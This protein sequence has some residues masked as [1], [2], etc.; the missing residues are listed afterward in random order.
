MAIQSQM[1]IVNNYQG[2]LTI[3]RIV[4]FIHVYLLRTKCQSLG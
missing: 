4:I 1:I 3:I 2:L